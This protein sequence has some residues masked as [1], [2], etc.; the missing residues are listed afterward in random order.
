M[1]H[2]SHWS[3][4]YLSRECVCVY[5]YI[6]IEFRGLGVGVWDLGFVGKKGRKLSRDDMGVIFP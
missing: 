6:Y 3:K 2:S 4:P 5:T 1:C